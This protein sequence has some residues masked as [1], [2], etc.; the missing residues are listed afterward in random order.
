MKSINIFCILLLSILSLEG[1]DI[2]REVEFNDGTRLLLKLKDETITFKR[3]LSNNKIKTIELKLSDTKEVHLTSAS[4]VERLKEIT[5][6]LEQLR[7]ENFKQRENAAAKLGSLG[8]GFQD[9]LK[10]NID[11]SLDPEVRWRLRRILSKLPPKS[12]LAF[13]QIRSE[14]GKLKGQVIKFNGTTQ[15]H[16]AELKLDR[17]S[18]KSIKQI[19]ERFNP[20]GY[21]I[22]NDEY[23]PEI[24][25]TNIKIDFNSSLKGKILRAGENIN[26]TY[27]SIGVSF[28]SMRQ[29]SYLT[30]SPKEIE[31]I[32][33][34]NSAT[35]HRPIFEG[36]ISA[37]FCNPN[38]PAESRAVS[39]LGLH[40]G[41]VKPGGT[42][43]IAYDSHDKK[44]EATTN[45]DGHQ[46]IGIMSKTPITR[47]TISANADIDTTFS[48]DDLIFTNLQNTNGPN[49]NKT[50]LLTLKNGDRI[51][52]ERLAFPSEINK[53]DQWLTAFP[54]AKGLRQLNIK[55][56]SVASIKINN[57]KSDEENSSPHLW[58]LLED[59]S[60]IKIHLPPELSPNSE[61]GNFSLSEL[62][63][64]ALWSSKNTLNYY[65]GELTVPNEGAAI[66]IRRDPVYVEDYVFNKDSFEGIR[67]D[68]SKIKYKF[69]RMPSIWFRKK[70]NKYELSTNLKLVDGQN[71]YCSNQS[72]FS[73]Q[74]ITNTHIILSAAEKKV[75]SIPLAKIN[76][77]NF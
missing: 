72:L 37:R 13:D 7:D 70:I 68:S 50:T 6:L 36:N 75:C 1:T 76:S 31:G 41:L 43:L 58:C 20:D 4:P 45:K 49:D 3:F 73:I 64:N 52:C 8:D 77:I 59:N 71:I 23:S 12:S 46:F 11:D 24:P 18:V 22:I 47:F 16:G 39:F 74:K 61:L 60:T 38:N 40:V 63:I 55:M 14:T 5:D 21:F 28:L 30:V 53:K 62:K 66:L 29:N 65:D 42:T 34:G 2:L 56:S 19:S 54:S 15:Y 51:S 69:S 27:E 44:I 17:E 10:N 33:H 26:K 9:I 57:L 48:F 25:I 67:K 32:K 35:N